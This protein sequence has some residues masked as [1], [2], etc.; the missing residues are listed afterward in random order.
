MFHVERYL[1]FEEYGSVL[2]AAFAGSMGL[3]IHAVVGF[4]DTQD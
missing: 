4:R 1:L 2:V 3:D